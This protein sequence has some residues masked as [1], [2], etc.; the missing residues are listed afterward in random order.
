M[1]RDVVI[2]SNILANTLIENGFNIKR[3]AFNK[4]DK[5]ESV[6]YFDNTEELREFLKVERDIIIK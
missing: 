3:V 1:D 2:F 6:Y 4:H 5:K